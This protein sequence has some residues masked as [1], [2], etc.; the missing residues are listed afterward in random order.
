MSRLI[1]GEA[2]LSVVK[3][4]ILLLIALV[5]TAAAAEKKKPSPPAP[6]PEKGLPLDDALSLDKLLDPGTSVPDILPAPEAI[7]AAPKSTAPRPTSAASAKAAL[8][9]AANDYRRDTALYR[10]GKLSREALKA[11]AVR[12]AETARTYRASLRRN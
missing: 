7:P 4:G 5:A 11:S 2:A 9:S 6:L 8:I 10:K 1:P 3:P 12:V